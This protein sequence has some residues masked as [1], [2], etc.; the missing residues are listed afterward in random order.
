MGLSLSSRGCFAD[1][2]SPFPQAWLNQQKGEFNVPTY[3]GRANSKPRPESFQRFRKKPKPENRLAGF[4]QH[5]HPS[6]R[7]PLSS[8]R[9][10]PVGG[11]R[12]RKDAGT[13]NRG[14]RIESVR[15][16]GDQAPVVAWFRSWRSNDGRVAAGAG[17]GNYPCRL[18]KV[19]VRRAKSSNSASLI[20]CVR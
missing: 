15:A 12:L 2:E 6:P 5:V 4:V 1:L 8:R 17:H 10:L 11:T 9:C 19:S 13:G 18:A 20:R 16:G 14:E 7:V 3:H